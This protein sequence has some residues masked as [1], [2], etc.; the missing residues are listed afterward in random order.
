[1]TEKYYSINEAGY[2]VRCKLYCNRP[3][4]VRA[5]VIAFHGFGGHKDNR[6]AMRFAERATSKK[7]DC[8]VL[9]FDFPCHGEDGQKKIS[10][11]NCDEYIKI[12][13]K[14]V[15]IRYP[16]AELYA[17]GTSFGGYLCLKFIW[18]NGNPF[19]K[20][21]L[22]CPVVKMYDA[23]VSA[24]LGPEELEKLRKGKDVLAGFDRKV[25]ISPD[26]LEEIREFDVS[27]KDYLEFADDILIMHGAKDEIVPIEDD[28][29]F[30]DDNV[31]EF[32][33]VPKADH[34]FT[35]PKIMDQAI[36]EGMKFLF[37]E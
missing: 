28:R 2:S 23:M 36:A 24:I 35:D 1:M 9:C 11:P 25:K 22:R 5:L 33:E 13:L 21:F 6:A 20:I 16:Q 8:A 14:D 15:S 19:R 34:R 18:E 17:Y 7:P 3:D 37:G 32:V 10:L 29:K 26:F 31:I 4:T 12:V 30:A 27:Q